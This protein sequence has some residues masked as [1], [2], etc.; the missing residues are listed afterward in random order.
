MAR[1]PGEPHYCRIMAALMTRLNQPGAGKGERLLSERRWPRAL[2]PRAT[3]RRAPAANC[4]PRASEPAA[5]R[6]PTAPAPLVRRS[7]PGAITSH[8]RPSTFFSKRLYAL[9]REGYSLAVR[10]FGVDG[11][12]LPELIRDPILPKVWAIC[13][14]A[15]SYPEALARRRSAP[16]TAGG[17]AA[18]AGKRPADVNCTAGSA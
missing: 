7:W 18:G 10:D 17:H 13:W 14:L 3:P 11:G 4:A 15:P 6:K 9:A 1:N 5:F 16:E 8:A 12:K 2:K